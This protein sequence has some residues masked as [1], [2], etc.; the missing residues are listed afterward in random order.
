M[1]VKGIYAM[2]I[3]KGF[4]MALRLNTYL[5]IFYSLRQQASAMKITNFRL[6]QSILNS[7]V[8]K[9]TCCKDQQMC[10]NHRQMGK[11]YASDTLRTKCVSPLLDIEMF[12]YIYSNLTANIDIFVSLLYFTTLFTITSKAGL[13]TARLL[14][15]FRHCFRL[16]VR[17]TVCKN[18]SSKFLLLL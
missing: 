5:Q 3:R 4:C 9:S 11:L 12:V 8:K 15:S 2:R 16:S 1:P 14:L 18:K 17:K 13:L 7:P 10:I 6:F